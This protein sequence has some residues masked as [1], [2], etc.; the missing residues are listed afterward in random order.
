ASDIE[1]LDGFGTN[2]PIWLRFDGPLDTDRLPDP[3]GSTA[4][5][6]PILLVDVDPDSPG[7][8]TRVPFSW[9]WQDTET[10]FQ[11]D[12]LLTIQPLWGMP[13]H[14]G[15]TYAVIVTTDIARPN[16]AVD[17]IFD[18]DD[19]AHDEWASVAETLLQLAIPQERV[20]AVTKFTTQD[21]VGRLAVFVDHIRT[22]VSIPS[23]DQA[24][25]QSEDLGYFTAWEGEIWLP[26]WQHGEKPFTTEG[27]G[28][29]VD[30]EGVPVLA[31]WER[32]T[33]TLSLPRDAE[34][35]A[36]GW[37]VV[38][39]EHG[40][41]GDHTTFAN[42]IGALEPAAVLAR[43]GLAGIGISLPLHGE[44]SAGG[45]PELLSFNYFNPTAARGNFQQAVLDVIYL[46]EVLTSGPQHFELV[47]EDGV[48]AGSAVLDPDSVAYMGHSHGGIVGAMAAPWLGD[49]LPA[50]FLSGAGGGLSLSLEYRKAGGLD[51]Q[52][53]I[54]D[55]F[56]LA[57]DEQVVAGH[58]L[59]GMVQTLGETVDPIN[60]AP[61]WHSRRPFWDAA[62]AHVLMTTGL[63]DEETPTITAQVLAGAGHLPVLSPVV[64]VQPVNELTGLVG[65][66]TPT[67]LNITAWDGSRV[68]GGLAEF[69]EDDHYA[70]FEDGDA[71]ALY[72]TFLSTA[73]SG[74]PPLVDLDID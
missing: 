67:S 4:T 22:A 13:L 23:L 16:D 53:L 39:Y 49:R 46:A 37:P 10:R 1:G 11:P 28:L 38:I 47:D 66:D 60:Y 40:T 42:G 50:I 7:R 48:G 43:S 55:T 2:A 72:A 69:A 70:I 59:V 26:F 17:G 74:S 41:G 33:F 34:M 3:A 30:D 56:E 63:L 29:E 12:R 14:P 54:T 73:L 44:R 57:P 18:L 36:D 45:D 64:Q 9:S 65:Q 31:G 35:P 58:P 8:G 61:Y 5:D 71:A 62:P 32:G 6:S 52:A 19:P 15:R 68:S 25:V 20:A 51:I 24:L 21:P 27:G